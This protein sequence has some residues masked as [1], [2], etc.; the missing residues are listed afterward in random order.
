[1]AERRAGLR[2]LRQMR[3][4]RLTGRRPTRRLQRCRTVAPLPRCP[5]LPWAC[6]RPELDQLGPESGHA[7]A[8]ISL[9]EVFTPVKESGEMR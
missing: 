1:M 9:E 4:R 6:E 3:N 8:A 5:A 2:E 7:R